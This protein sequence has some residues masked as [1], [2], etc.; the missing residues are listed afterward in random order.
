MSAPSALLSLI[1]AAGLQAPQV[2]TPAAPPAVVERVAVAEVEAAQA[3]AW[4]PLNAGGVSFAVQVGFLDAGSVLKLRETRGIRRF[5]WPRL[6][7]GVGLE[8]DGRQ[9]YLHHSENNRRLEVYLPLAFDAPSAVAPIAAVLDVQFE[10]GRRLVIGPVRYAMFVEPGL[11]AEP[12]Y[13]L[14]RRDAEGDFWVTH[15]TARELA[16]LRW[17][18]AVDGTMY[19]FR[20][21]GERLVLHAQPV[22]A[23]GALNLEPETRRWVR[24]P[25]TR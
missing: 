14:L 16:D 8:L 22:P 10:R 9:L 18:L 12:G 2:Q 25:K 24:D 13:G 11:G 17:F 19:G 1:A 23:A 4:F 21:E 6:A 5:S 15:W 20:L 7:Q 3:A